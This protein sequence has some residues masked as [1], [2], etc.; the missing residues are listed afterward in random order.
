MVKRVERITNQHVDV[1]LSEQDTQCLKDLLLADPR[2]EKKRIQQRKE[3]LLQDSFSWVLGQE[4]FVKWR[5]NDEAQLL[6][7]K[8]DPGKGKT[9]L[10]IGII[11]ELSSNFEETLDAGVLSYFFCQGT[12]S[13]LNNFV[14]VLRGL[15]YHLVIQRKSAISHIREKYSHSGRR[16]FEDAIAVSEIFEN[17][18]RDPQILPA[19]LIID[20]LDECEVGRDQ[21]IDLIVRNTPPSARVKWIVSSRNQQDIEECLTLDSCQVRLS[22]ELNAESVSAA[23]ETYIDH[24]V[25]G[26]ARR[27]SYNFQ[28]QDQIR[29]YLHANAGGTFLWV[30]LVCQQLNSNIL[31][32]KWSS[33]LKDFPPGLQSLYERIME[34]ICHLED[35]EAV[36]LCKEILAVTTI[37]YRPIRLT[38]L[39]SITN[40]SGQLSND[41]E[42]LKELVRLCGS[43]LI[44]RDDIIYFVHQ[45]VKDYLSTGAVAQIFPTGYGEVHHRVLLQS[46]QAMSKALRRDIYNLREPGTLIKNVGSIDPDPLGPLRYSCV[47][48][49]DHLCE[50]ESSLQYQHELHNGGI[51]HIFLKGYFLHWLEALSLIGKLPEGFHMVAKLSKHLSALRVS[52]TV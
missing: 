5:E 49:V 36:A 34:Q 20:A 40:L 3:P 38:E 23:V 39:F 28:T 17:I 1:Q 46:L 4:D 15:I 2:L 50:T 51:I 44:V 37:A 52:D 29:S 13:R 26:L 7:V 9:M 33:V 31:R 30:A 18:L 19:Y 25:T 8:G 48:W 22:L 41:L 10:L 16:L 21:L 24:K 45:S 32:W 11:D 14:A 43:F 35:D 6:W 12:D 42:S 27:K 47:Y